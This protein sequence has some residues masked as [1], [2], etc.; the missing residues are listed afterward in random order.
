MRP[1]R[2][3]LTRI[4]G[5]NNSQTS[6]STTGSFSVPGSG[7][8]KFPVP[9]KI[10]ESE[11]NLLKHRLGELLKHAQKYPELKLSEGANRLHTEWY[12]KREKSIHSKRLDTYSLRLMPLF[13]VNSLKNGNVNRKLTICDNRIL[14]TPEQCLKFEM[15]RVNHLTPSLSGRA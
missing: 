8:A 14:T 6:G 5:I 7:E 13:A 10:P 4:P 9:A 11:K 2:F 1:A 12:M 15:T 3:K